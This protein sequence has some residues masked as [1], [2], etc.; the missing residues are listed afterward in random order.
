[1]RSFGN[2]LQTEGQAQRVAEV[3]ELEAKAKELMLE[4]TAT[5]SQDAREL[6]VRNKGLIE[7]STGRPAD[8]ACKPQ[9]TLS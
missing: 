8:S 9:H 6:N 3:A 1:M 4:Y 7:S 2:F 5:A